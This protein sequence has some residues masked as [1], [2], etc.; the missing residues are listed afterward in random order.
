MRTYHIIHGSVCDSTFINTKYRICVFC[1]TD[2]CLKISCVDASVL[3]VSVAKTYLAAVFLCDVCF[4]SVLMHSK[5]VHAGRALWWSLRRITM[6]NTVN[7]F[8]NI[9]TGV[10]IGNMCLIS[11]KWFEPNHIKGACC[12]FRA[13]FPRPILLQ[14]L[15]D[16]N[17]DTNTT[18]QY[19]YLFKYW[20][21]LRALPGCSKSLLQTG[22][23]CGH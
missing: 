1:I 13:P 15:P 5:S 21:G 2:M 16:S 6:K 23:Y 9:C 11:K 4:L 19:G 10:Y 20:L 3:C 8:L 14:V 12:V 17:P 22:V 7:L 18:L